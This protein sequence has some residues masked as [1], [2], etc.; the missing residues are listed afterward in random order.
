MIMPHGKNNVHKNRRNSRDNLPLF[1]TICRS[2]AYETV[3]K[4][5]VDDRIFLTFFGPKSSTYWPSLF[6]DLEYF[7]KF[8]DLLAGNRLNRFFHIGETGKW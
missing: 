1:S 8:L 4:G 5:R 7:K 6:G 2:I 3:F